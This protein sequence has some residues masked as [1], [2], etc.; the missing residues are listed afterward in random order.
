[1]GSFVVIE[2]KIDL[3][4]PLQCR[5]RRVFLEI[6]FFIFDTVPQPFDEDIVE[7]P[8]PAIPA[9]PDVGVLQA[10]LSQSLQQ[11]DDDRVCIAVSHWGGVA[12]I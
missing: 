10:E 11:C 1:M 2:E 9:D 5:D 6:D 4:T 8:T 7:T 3:Q 12:G